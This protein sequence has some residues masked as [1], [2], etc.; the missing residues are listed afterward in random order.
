MDRVIGCGE[1]VA[2][3][4]EFLDDELADHDHRAVDEH[5]AFCRQCCGELEFA[6]QLRRLLATKGN[7]ELPFRVQARFERYIAEL[8]HRA[9]GEGST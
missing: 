3:L 6:K 1:A 7:V 5:L 9:G 4:W 2:R 8:N